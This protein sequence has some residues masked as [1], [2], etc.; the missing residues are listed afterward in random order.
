[1]LKAGLTGNIGSGKTTVAKV[2]HSFGIPVFDA[3]SQAKNALNE[4]V[5][6][7]KLIAHFGPEI[8]ESD[9]KIDKKLFAHLVFNDPAA[10]D[11]V[12]KLI[13]PIVRQ[14]FFDFCEKHAGAPFCIYEAAIII[15]T[16]FYKQLDKTILVAA[17]ESLRIQRVKKRDN[18]SEET[19][20]ERMKNQWPE[21]QKISTADFV[22]VNDEKL[23]LLEQCIEVYDK[24][25]A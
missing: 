7:E 12:N 16:G 8:S 10:L 3:D 1:M 9:N 20:R 21:E 4:S 19:I 15:E 17:P 23:P 22:I 11:Y 13:H 24:I 6:L 5:Q 18:L 14:R 25:G 2:F